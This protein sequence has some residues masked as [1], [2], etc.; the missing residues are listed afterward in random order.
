MT[1]PYF[2]VQGKTGICANTTIPQNVCQNSQ[3]TIDSATEAANPLLQHD[4]ACAMGIRSTRAEHLNEAI[5]FDFGIGYNWTVSAWPYITDTQNGTLLVVLPGRNLNFAWNGLTERYEGPRGFELTYDVY[6]SQFTL[7]DPDGRIW[8]FVGFGKALTPKGRFFNL[9][10][11]NGETATVNGY[12]SY[13]HI[14]RIVTRRRQGSS[15]AEETWDYAYVSCDDGAERLQTFTIQSQVAGGSSEN[16]RRYSYT[17]TIDGDLESVTES[18]YLDAQW[19]PQGVF[20]YRYA[21]DGEPHRLQYALH[22]EQF[23]ALSEDPEV[24]DPWQATDEQVA[25]YATYYFEY[26][27]NHRLSYRQPL[28]GGASW[29]S[30]TEGDATSTDPNVVHLQTVET[31][32]D[33]S[34]RTSLTNYRNQ[35]LVT[36][37]KESA[38]ESTSSIDF[39]EYTEDGQLALH[40]TPSAMEDYQLSVEGGYT[41]EPTY[42]SE[43]GQYNVGLIHVYDY[44]AETTT[45]TG[46]GAA[47]GFLQ[48][49]KIRKGRDG[50]DITLRSLEYTEHSAEVPLEDVTWSSSSSSSSGPA[51]VEL[52]I[53]PP[54]RETHYRNDD[55]TGAIETESS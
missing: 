34:L 26:D 9:T 45:G 32:A 44:Y 48:G 18:L 38:N 16:V 46:G 51:T 11:P 10:A 12:T 47:T 37:F 20:Y 39:Y 29:F 52:T 42:R 23:A 14:T 17:Y 19:V 3:Q 6:A 7:K 41:V 49:E 13:G 36:E 25:Q 21:A 24:S 2:F 1:L 22:P 8:Q 5:H 50:A 4:R 27:A 31:R 54:A 15:W 33:G 28:A 43:N 40:A 30:Y 53:Y 55:G 35:P